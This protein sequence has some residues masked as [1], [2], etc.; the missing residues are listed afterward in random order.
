VLIVPDL[1][2][3]N[4]DFALT[5]IGKTFSEGISALITRTQQNKESGLLSNVELSTEKVTLSSDGYLLLIKEYYQIFYTL[6]MRII[7]GNGLQTQTD[8]ILSS[9]TNS[10]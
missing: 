4:K 5:L 6:N 1:S 7:F 3:N 8:K 9:A 10:R 2:Q